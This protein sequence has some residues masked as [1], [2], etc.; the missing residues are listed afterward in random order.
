MVPSGYETPH[1][2]EVPNK[3][4][5]SEDQF[6]ELLSNRTSR[7]RKKH[8]DD[9]ESPSKRRKIKHYFINSTSPHGDL[10]FTDEDGSGNKIQEFGASNHFNL[11]TA[12]PTSPSNHHRHHHK[13]KHYSTT[14]G[15]SENFSV[16]TIGYSTT[17]L[18]T[19]SAFTTQEQPLSSRRPSRTEMS[20]SSEYK[21]TAKVSTTV[22][23][24]TLIAG[25]IYIYIY[26]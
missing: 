6:I 2:Y 19:T 8:P 1:L 5:S 3:T 15:Y 25:S 17:T 18:K 10:N 4:N 23:Y 20:H 16:S 13:Q 26:T 22:N 21:P 7:K 12:G 24:L 11:T 14:G 9:D